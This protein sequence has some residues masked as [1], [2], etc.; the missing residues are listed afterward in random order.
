MPLVF[1]WTWE[2]AVHQV[3]PMKRATNEEGDQ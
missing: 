3:K 1:Q 2:L